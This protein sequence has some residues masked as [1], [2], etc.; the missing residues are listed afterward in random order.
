MKILTVSNMYP[1]EKDKVYGTF[2]KNFF[3]EVEKRNP[4][5]VNDLVALKG[6]RKGIS[7]KLAGYVSFY[8]RLLYRLLFRN[9]D[10]I[11]VH[12]VTFPIIP[13]RIAA[14]VKR[15]PLVFNV[16]GDDVLPSNTLKK[17]LKSLSKALLPEAKLVVSPSEYFRG[18]VLREFPGVRAENV[19]VS[20][21]GGVASRFFV[22]HKPSDDSTLHLGYVS[23]IDPGKGWDVLLKAVAALK[24][25]EIKCHLTIIGRGSEVGAMEKMIRD[26]D[27]EECVEYLGP[28]PQD[29]LPGL[30]SSFDLFIF[31]SVRSAESLGLVG[32]EA[33]A[34]GT[35][36]AG[37]DMAGISSYVEDGTNGYLFRPGDAGD[38]VVKV[39][40][41]TG[42]SRE[43]RSEMSAKA[44]E[45]A[46]KY[47]ATMVSDNLYSK[48]VSLLK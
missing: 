47:D 25:K 14:S 18:V 3:E 48:L 13:L 19:F 45:T 10:L 22:Q 12:T 26:L 5:G 29:E 9:Y 34:A 1:S 43:Q 16:H 27:L 7:G 30:Y 20:P 28:K 32:L 4:A 17:K 6:R 23:R 38:L 21:S 40:A 36:V 37:S 35:P 33:M 11:Y 24:T 2:V 15:L 41:Y 46:R 42:L 39:E 31:P 44:V 8:S